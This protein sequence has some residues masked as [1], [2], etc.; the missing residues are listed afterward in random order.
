M[1]TDEE[2]M[3]RALQ[4]AEQA[5][6]EDE[7]PVGAVVVKD[8]HIIAE[9]SNQ[10]IQRHDPTA[11]AE[12]IALRKAGEVL[13]NYRLVD[14]TLYVTLEPCPMCANAMVHARINRLVFGADDPRTGAAGSVFNLVQSDKLNHQVE[15][16][17]G[18][19]AESCGLILSR[20]FQQRRK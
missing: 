7:V 11:H 2:Y 6:A 13:G 15:V 3:Q 20:F 1:N 5:Q 12:I 16:T 18:I 10:P 9:A 8:N 17:R 4:L 19:L 14:C